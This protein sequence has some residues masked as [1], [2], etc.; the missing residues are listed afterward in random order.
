MIVTITR[1]QHQPL[2]AFRP[3]S[4][5]R[6]AMPKLWE[7]IKTITITQ[8]NREVEIKVDKPNE[9]LLTEFLKKAIK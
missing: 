5:A 9:Q 7:C 2:R 6:Y 4:F 1:T 8:G 3:F